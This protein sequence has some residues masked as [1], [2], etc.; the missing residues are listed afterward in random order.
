MNAR[1][2]LVAV[3]DG[4]Q[5]HEQTGFSLQPCERFEQTGLAGENGTT[6]IDALRDH[7]SDEE[8]TLDRVD[9]SRRAVKLQ[10]AR[11]GGPSVRHVRQP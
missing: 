1:S 10:R 2:Q 3:A 6:R 4:G 7:S 9:Q 5:Q 8:R 11:P